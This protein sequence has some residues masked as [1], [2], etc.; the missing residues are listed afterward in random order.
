MSGQ[1]TKSDDELKW[2]V[3]EMRQ[4]FNDKTI[5]DWMHDDCG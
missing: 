4:I 2:D 1:W 5:S 3:Q